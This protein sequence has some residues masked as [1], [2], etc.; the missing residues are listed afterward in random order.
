M[1]EEFERIVGEADPAFL[2]HVI[3]N[4]RLLAEVHG[5]PEAACS[6]P[7]ATPS[8]STCSSRWRVVKSRK[9]DSRGGHRQFHHQRRRAHNHGRHPFFMFYASFWFGDSYPAFSKDLSP[10]SDLF[11]PGLPAAVP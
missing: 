6:H 2:E 10:P 5:W 11:F 3:E 8:C 4:R 9:A 7:T 1:D